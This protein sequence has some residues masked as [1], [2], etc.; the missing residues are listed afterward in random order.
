MTHIGP[1]GASVI[2]HA[3]WSLAVLVFLL[4]ACGAP[5]PPHVV[6]VTFDT[7]RYDRFG[8]TGDSGARTPT[9]DGLAARGLAFDHAYATV[10]L[11]LPSHT[12]IMSG[13]PP[14]SH[15]VHNNGRFQVPESL[16]TLAERL[17]REAGVRAAFPALGP[18]LRSAP[19]PPG[20]AVLRRASRSLCRG[21]RL[22]R[23][24]TGATPRGRRERRRGARHAGRLHLRSRRGIR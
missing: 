11:T 22:C 9:V 6:I 24:P 18:L 10:A 4:G 15:G 23:R 16:E 5:P 19:S 3:S 7:A 14:L 21:D 17:A 8:F 2:A 20:A 1:G 12:T 13:V